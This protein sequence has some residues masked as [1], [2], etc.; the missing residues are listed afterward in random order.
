MIGT[1]INTGTV[2]LGSSIGMLIKSKL[3]ERIVEGV[4]N[5]LGVFTAFLGIWMSIGLKGDY[6]LTVVLSLVLGTI[7]GEGLLMEQKLNLWLNR[8]NSG[9]E[10]EKSFSE[11]II[12][13]FLLF[14]VGSMTLLGTFQEGLTG[15]RDLI[16]TKATMDLFSSAALASAFGKS[17]LFS[18]I[19]LFVFQ[20]GLTLAASYLEPVLTE[21]VQELIFSTGGIV[22]VALGFNILLIAPVIY[23]IGIW[24]S[25]I[26]PF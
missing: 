21:E 16:V 14:C 23:E 20:G 1:L 26:L 4:F 10:A 24:L 11:G 6:I 7:I 25:D 17:I 8:F 13:A 2:I 9:E 15:N 18:A 3:P 12:T 5:A 19:P 22:M